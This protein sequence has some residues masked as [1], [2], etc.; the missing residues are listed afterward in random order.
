MDAGNFARAFSSAACC[1]GLHWSSA[2]PAAAAS[3]GADEAALAS[4]CC[5]A[6]ADAED[7]VEF[8]PATPPCCCW[9]APPFFCCCFC[10]T[11]APEPVW[12]WADVCGFC[13]A[14]LADEFSKG[15]LSSGAAV[16]SLKAPRLW[17]WN[18][19]NAWADILEPIDFREAPWDISWVFL[20]TS[21]GVL[22]PIIW[23]ISCHLLAAPPGCL[24]SP[25]AR[26]DSSSGVQSAALAAFAAFASSSFL[27]FSSAF[28]ASAK[29]AF[30]SLSF[31]RPSKSSFNAA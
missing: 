5:F 16:M 20:M 19:S 10:L 18:C 11:A 13:C 6:G 31:W 25:F 27:F 2:P 26:R 7:D 9:F 17:E 29:R 24:C 8:P 15:S 14:G 28:L 22:V 4:S 3:L 12:S 30:S 21:S 23:E 1:S